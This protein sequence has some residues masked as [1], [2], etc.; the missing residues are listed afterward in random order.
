LTCIPTIIRAAKMTKNL[1]VNG[2]F[3]DRKDMDEIGSASC[4]VVCFSIRNV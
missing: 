4:L 2:H 1:L 3:E